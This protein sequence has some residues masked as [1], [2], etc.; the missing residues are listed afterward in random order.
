MAR[1]RIYFVVQPTVAHYREP[2]LRRLLESTRYDFDLVGRFKNSESTAADAIHSAADEVLAKVR[3]LRFSA[4]REFWWEHGQVREIWAGA[5]DAYVIAGRIPTVSAWAACAVAA[6]RGRTLIMWGHGWKR[7][8]DGL[9]RRVRLAFYRLTDGLLVYGDRAKELGSSYG[10]PAE[11]IQ[12]I[13]NSIYPEALIG[14]ARETDAART[15]EAADDDAGSPATIIYSS[16]LTT[17]HRLDL[18]AEALGGMP[19]AARPKLLIVGEGAERPRL[20]QVFAEH[21]VDAEFLG[22]VYDYEQ[23]RG[24]YARADLAVSVGGAGLNVTQAMSFGVPVLAED[25]NPDSSPE[26]EAVVEGVT[27]RHYQTGDA[28]SLRRVLAELLAAPTQLRRLGEASLA[29]VRERYTA[30]KHAEAIEDALD[31]LL[32]R[33]KRG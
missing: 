3:P 20:E 13:Y 17:R 25:G 24:L 33:A 9:K 2:L 27:G 29:V 10:V 22:A 5:H 30:E 23:L 12:V 28:G 15:A 31:R 1:P 6:L 11:K 26:I 14:S 32:A 19:D 7:P 16:R 18:L 4:I 21:G 8:E